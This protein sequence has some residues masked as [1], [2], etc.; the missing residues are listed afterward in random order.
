MEIISKSSDVTLLVKDLKEKLKKQ[1]Q[2]TWLLIRKTTYS[3]F[4]LSAK[5]LNI[6]T[7]AK[8]LK[9]RNRKGSDE[10]RS[11]P[12]GNITKDMIRKKYSKKVKLFNS[13]RHLNICLA[14]INMNH[15]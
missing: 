5:L 4:T 3:D 8:S 2:Q 13:I 14:Y 12:L 7:M 15:I 6:M 11:V 1:Y 10:K 9:I